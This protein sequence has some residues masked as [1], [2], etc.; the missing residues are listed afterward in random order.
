MR[1]FGLSLHARKKLP[2][3]WTFII[4][5]YLF[6]EWVYNQH[7]LQLL[8]YPSVTAQQFEWT[9]I[10]GKAIASVGLNLVLAKCYKRPGIIKFAVGVCLTYMALSWF[11]ERVIDSFPDEFRHSSYYG[12][13]HRK[14]VVQGT[15][16]GKILDFTRETRWH[17]RPLVLSQ[18]YLTLE[19]KQW[20]A[21]ESR[22][23]GPLDKKANT[24]LKD[25]KSLWLKY[26]QAEEARQYVE[27][28]WNNYG[29]A[30]SQYSRYRNHP[31]H[32]K[33]ARDTFISRV[34][35]PPD[36]THEE[37]VRTKA[38]KYHVYLTTVLIEG[39][40]ELGV[41]TIRG[42][43][44]PLRMN[45]AAFYRYVD[46]TAR[47]IRTAVAPDTKE[48]RDNASSKDAVALLVIPPL[49]IGLSLLSIVINLIGLACTWIAVFLPQGIVRRSACGLVCAIGF[50][51]VAF[52]YISQ[53]HVA[54]MDPY[55]TQ[56]DKAFEQNHPVVWAAM[57]LPMRM[58]P[59]LCFTDRPVAW[60][61]KGMEILYR[62]RSANTNGISR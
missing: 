23:R 58:E 48:I 55:W 49:S 21:I 52:G 62:P 47:D 3:A 56:L 27:V 37:F 40:K 18:Y 41:P 43:D 61:G 6:V 15:D 34:G 36:L 50:C 31:R 20:A 28:G 22:L 46:D 42:S 1:I 38:K 24:A 14:D 16:T 11:F 4:L 8:E 60:I 5:S 39:N 53:P 12:V 35:A 32:A 57:S 7:L 10:F 59:F 33:R 30:M 44:V 2:I 19:D 29:K 9:E 25:K 13:M 54:R 17:V 26:E 45:Q 51:G